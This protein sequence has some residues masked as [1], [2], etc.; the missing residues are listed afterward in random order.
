MARI[1]FPNRVSLVNWFLAVTA[2]DPSGARFIYFSS[3][4]GVILF[5]D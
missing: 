2:S 1:H 5:I 3:S 4:G